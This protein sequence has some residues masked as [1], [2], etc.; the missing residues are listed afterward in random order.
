MFIEQLVPTPKHPTVGE[1]YDERVETVKFL[2]D[3]GWAKAA[4]RPLP[5]LEVRS[6]ISRS[7]LS[8][9]I[10]RH[11]T[12]SRNCGAVHFYGSCARRVQFFHGCDA[13]GPTS[14]PP[15]GPRGMRRC[16]L[17]HQ[18][19]LSRMRNNRTA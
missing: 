9:E 6:T 19:T 12:C 7:D 18:A 15:D 11:G 5:P 16:A 14:V 13:P 3:Q 2:I 1:Q 10:G 8:G 17:T 4:T